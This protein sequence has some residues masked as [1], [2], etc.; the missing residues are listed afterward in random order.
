MPEG[1]SCL[2]EVVGRHFDTH[3]IAYA[4]ANEVLAHFTGDVGQ[5]FV[6]IGKRNAKHRARK[7]LHHRA[8]QLNRFFFCHAISP[9]ILHPAS[10]PIIAAGQ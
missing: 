10:G 7:H 1:D 8:N 9:L 5:D 4:D 2:I 6:P 3:A